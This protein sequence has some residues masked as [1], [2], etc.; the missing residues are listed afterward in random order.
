MPAT[1]Q[2]LT[3]QNP[4]LMKRNVL[5]SFA[6]VLLIPVTIVPRTVGALVVTG[7]TAAVNGLSMLNPQRWG[8]QGSKP[9]ASDYH[10]PSGDKEEAYFEN[11][12]DE[13]AD[14]RCK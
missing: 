12:H 5:A 4:A 13:K 10:T 2:F 8:T 6:N 7:G 1:A 11:Q 9:L 14:R 3:S